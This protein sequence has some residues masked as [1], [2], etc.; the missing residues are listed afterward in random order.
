MFG[1]II[2]ADGHNLLLDVL[3]QAVVAQTVCEIEVQV[4]AEKNVG[5]LP[6]P[7]GVADFTAIGADGNKA[8]VM[9]TIGQQNQQAANQIG[10]FWGGQFR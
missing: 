4:I 1:V 5:R 2:V 7:F 3:R 6:L 10:A 8:L 9:V